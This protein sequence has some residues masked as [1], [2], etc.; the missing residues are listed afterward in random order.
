LLDRWP[1]W[2]TA[3]FAAAMALLIVPNLSHLAPKSWSDIDLSFWTPEKIA[4]SGV[5]VTTAAEYVS[6]WVE[7]PPP[8]SRNPATVVA[9]DATVLLDERTPVAWSADVK[10][11]QPST[12][13]LTIAYFPGWQV[14]LDGEAVPI[15]PASPSGQIRFDVPPGDHRMEVRWSRTRAVWIGD[16]ISLASLVGL[17]AMAVWR[18]SPKRTLDPVPG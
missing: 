16:A 5:E 7:A 15:A 12:V 13:Q 2:R 1:R 18:R 14:Q 17:I 9:G 11:S 10:A 8:Y 6:K 3:G 4:S